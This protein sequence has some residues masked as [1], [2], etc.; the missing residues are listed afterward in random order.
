M[1]EVIYKIRVNRPCRLFIDEEEVMTLE[2]S[3]LTKITLPVGEYLRKV[4]AEDDSTVFKEKVISLFHPTVDDIALDAVSLEEEKRNALPKEIFQ[5]NLYFHPTRDKL[6][7][8]VVDT[9][10]DVDTI[11]IPDQIKYAG[12]VYPVTEVQIIERDIKSIT[13]PSGVKSI[14][15]KDCSLLTSVVISSGA[16]CIG[17]RTF[18]GCYSLKS[19]TIPESV[20]EIGSLAFK[21]CSSLTAI[22]Y[23]GTKEQWEN[24]EKGYRLIES[25]WCGEI[26]GDYWNDESKIKVIRCKD[27]EIE[28]EGKLGR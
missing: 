16:T 12:Y 27:G 23:A 1:S 7:V 19:I 8:R 17:D 9:N 10:K 25:E 24:I 26:L 22:D 5:G 14:W 2:E 3:K 13:I 18:E 4:V 20:T 28:V 6:S 21:G 11:N 15:L